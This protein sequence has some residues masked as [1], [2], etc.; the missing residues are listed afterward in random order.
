MDSEGTIAVKCRFLIRSWLPYDFEQ[1]LCQSQSRTIATP[2]VKALCAMLGI[3]W[4]DA[5]VSVPDL[6]DTATQSRRAA[7]LV[8]NIFGARDYPLS[9][10][11][12]MLC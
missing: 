5:L 11:I 7:G 12:F 2:F 1:F 6:V 10:P 4:D 8:A 9:I 3:R